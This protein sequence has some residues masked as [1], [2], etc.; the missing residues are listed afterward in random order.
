M[1]LLAAALLLAAATPSRAAPITLDD[2]LAEAARGSADLAIAR[3]DAASA[4]ADRAAAVSGVLPR[5]DLSAS[6]GHTFVG[7]RTGAEAF[8]DPITNQ[9]VGRASDSE[10]YTAGLQLTQTIFDWQTFREIDRA[11]WNRRASERQYDETALTVAFEVTRRFYE[12]V[13]AERSL[14]VLEKA[15]ARSEE[16]VQRADALFTAGRAPKSDT[17]SARS[18]LQGDRIAVEAQRI[19]DAEARSALAQAL[20][21]SGGEALEV[22]APAALDAPG[23][24]SGEVAPLEV[25]LARARE[26]RPSLAAQRALVEAAGAGIGS[27]RAGYLPTLS[28]Q[29]AYR[30]SLDQ[31][32]GSGGVYDD[33]ARDYTASA[34]LVVSWN[35]FEGRRTVAN[36]QRA[37]AQVTRARASEDRAAQ[38][39]AKELADAQSRVSLLAAQVA[40]SADNVGLAK[41]ALSLATQ[42]LEAGL[43][44]QLEIRDAS[45]RLTQAELSLAQS[46]IDHAVATADLARAVG[47]AL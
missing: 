14:A 10:A 35:L 33:P 28:A 5:L 21:R 20:G 8:V 2:A 27:A 39:V 32:A 34:Q 6:F 18:N 11:G 24:P 19:R 13:R 42:R 22:A 26:R 12:V 41:E 7:E 47:G 40:L 37:E 4:G 29:G 46:R 45:L 3:A 30:R 25:L 1:R 43:A 23:L 44:S 17:F 15:A 38:D 31:L 9:V 16:L 36:L